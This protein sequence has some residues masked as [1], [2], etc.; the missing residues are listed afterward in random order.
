MSV[1]VGEGLTRE[2][3]VTVG[4]LACLPLCA[5]DGAGD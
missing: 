5:P 2:G 3:R 1:I 4:V